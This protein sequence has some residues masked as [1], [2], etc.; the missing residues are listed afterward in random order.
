MGPSPTRRRGERRGAFG[1][2]DRTGAT[3]G[4]TNGAEGIAIIGTQGHRDER[5]DRPRPPAGP[6]SGSAADVGGSSRRLGDVSRVGRPI[7]CAFGEWA[8]EHERLD[9]G[10]LQL[11]Q[12]E[13]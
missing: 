4:L 13:G 5:S 6:D 11:I 10:L 8:I 3:G 9:V 1:R 7:A 12:K 2:D